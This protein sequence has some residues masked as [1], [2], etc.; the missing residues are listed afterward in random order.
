[1]LISKRK[2]GK[3]V[4]TWMLL[5]GF[6]SL[7]MRAEEC[8]AYLFPQDVRT[9]S[10][11]TVVQART[12]FFRDDPGCPEGGE[13]C[14]TKSYLVQGD[15]VFTAQTHGQYRCAAFF[16]GKHQTTGWIR[17]DSLAPVRWP[18]ADDDWSG[19]WKRVQGN[20]EINIRKQGSKYIAEASATYAVSNDNVRTG[21]ASGPLQIQMLNETTIASFGEPGSDRSQVCRVELRRSGSLLLAADGV[22]ENSNSACGGMGVTLTGIYRRKS[23]GSHGTSQSR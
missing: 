20:A 6:S 17:Q 15:R 10:F 23:L 9:V 3:T 2:A 14:R 5:C 1:M 4:A 19:K 22:T 21:E 12:S 13:I 8:S 11:A 18:I 16:D 7:Y